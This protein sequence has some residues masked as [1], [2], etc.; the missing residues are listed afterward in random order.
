[1]ADWGKLT[2]RR[3]S[4]RVHSARQQH[5]HCDDGCHSGAVRKCGRHS[6]CRNAQAGGGKRERERERERERAEGREHVGREVERKRGGD[7][8]RRRG[9]TAGWSAGGL[10]HTGSEWTRRG[11]VG[12]VVPGL[13][14][15]HLNRICSIVCTSDLFSP[16]QTRPSTQTMIQCSP[17]LARLPRVSPCVGPFAAC[18][19]AASS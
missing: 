19:E 3:D 13:A 10:H 6:L 15:L 8:G 1:M 2:Q 7:G 4:V 16:T 12:G 9:G 14:R 17:A 11:Y 18:V 5:G